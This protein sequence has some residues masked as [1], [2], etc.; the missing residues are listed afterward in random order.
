MKYQYTKEDLAFMKNKRAPQK[1]STERMAGKTCVVS[2]STSGV[3][4]E[5][6]AQLAKGGADIVLVC[7]NENKAQGV[8]AELI[9]NYPVNVDIV[10]AD[11]SRLDDVRRAATEIAERYPVIDL[12]INSAGLHSTRRRLTE[13]G[14][15]LVF[16]VNHIAPFLL[17]MMLLDNIKKSSQ[18]RIIQVN[19][20]GHRFGGVNMGDLNWAKR[21]YMG[22]RAYGASKTAQI[23]TVMT[24]ARQLEGTNVT[25]NAMH[26]GGV[27][28][29]I[30]KN[31]GWLYRTW[32][33]AFIWPF[34]KDPV[35][36]GDALYYLASATELSKTSGRYFNLTIDEKPMP[37]ALDEEIQ[38]AIWEKSL[39][40]AGLTP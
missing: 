6:A 26:P 39:A 5:A 20:E 16:Q 36:S 13:D 34:L 40:L 37:H 23:M 25:I 17:T 2:G 14:N 30:G 11:F 28:T 9:K 10:V 24:L 15:E 1:K 33:R 21:H 3:G 38:K 19:S 12:L 32:Q 29:N 31:N 8:R 27:R 22:L 18:G 4:L 7:R 35:I